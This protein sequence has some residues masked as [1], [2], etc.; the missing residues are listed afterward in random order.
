[1]TNP[2][3]SNNF[4]DDNPLIHSSDS[5]PG[6]IRPLDSSIIHRLSSGQVI[7]DLGQ[8]V[9]ELIENSVDAKSTTIEIIIKNHGIESLT[10]IDNGSGITSENYSKIG[11]KH[12]TSKLNSFQDLSKIK[13]FGFRGEALSSLCALAHVT[14]STRSE[15]DSIGCELTFDNSGH[16]IKQKSQVRNIGTTL[17]LKELFYSLPVRRKTF[18]KNAK[19]DYQKMIDLISGYA[20]IL[21]GIKIHVVHSL[22]GQRNTVLRTQ[23]SLSQLD[24]IDNIYGNKQAENLQ[25]IK[26]ELNEFFNEINNNNNNNYYNNENNPNNETIDLLNK[27]GIYTITG[28]ISKLLGGAG[29]NLNDRHHLAINGRPV[30]LPVIDRA[31]IDAYRECNGAANFPCYIINI[32]IPLNSYDVNV[33]P[34]K[35]VVLIH[36]E[37]ILAA[38]VRAALIQSWPKQHFFKVQNIQSFYLT[39]DNKKNSEEFA[40]NEEEEVELLHETNNNSDREPIPPLASQANLQLV[41]KSIWDDPMLSQ[42]QKSSNENKEVNEEEMSGDENFDKD[43]NIEQSH[44]STSDTNT[45]PRIKTEPNL[46]IIEDYSLTERRHPFFDS[47]DE[48]VSQHQQQAAPKRQKIPLV[49]NVVPTY[50]PRIDNVTTRTGAAFTIELHDQIDQSASSIQTA[51]SDDAPSYKI[52]TTASR[53]SSSSPS[54]LSQPFSSLTTRSIQV[55]FQQIENYW[56]KQ[57]QKQT[58]KENLSNSPAINNIDE[59]LIL[60]STSS[61]SS[62]AISPPPMIVSSNDLIDDTRHRS[63]SKSDFSLM[64]DSIIGQFNLGFIICK[65]N[66]DLWIIDQHAADEKYKYEFYKKTLKSSIHSQQCLSLLPLHLTPIQNSIMIQNKHVFDDLGFGLVVENKNNGNDEKVLGISRIPHYYSHTFGIEDIYEVIAMLNQD[67]THDDNDRHNQ[68]AHTNSNI[69]NHHQHHSHQDNSDPNNNNN[70]IEFPRLRS[71]LASRACRR[72]IMIGESLPLTTM[73]T[74]ISHMSELEQPWS[75]PHGRPTMRHLIDINSFCEQKLNKENSIIKA[76]STETEFTGSSSD[77]ENENEN[78]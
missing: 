29:R 21:M 26:T 36:G 5:S 76:K 6:V 59:S 61:S 72:A 55:N 14:I 30:D 44:F 58:N 28:Y 15:N 4:I 46:V 39:K 52:S 25:L 65:L 20:M 35:R 7:Y 40:A 54:S 48:R 13:T 74:I 45:S 27:Y 38:A 16:C 51:Q 57:K 50:K 75:C 47:F 33:T 53:P 19:R 17:T 11:L 49:N 42:Y 63:I 23:G 24:C 69:N 60:S 68:I 3:H 73:K 43:E 71:I 64:S 32:D 31:I 2:N 34:N 18:T 67:L 78:V 77:D 22:N 66:S 37:N 10:I 8:T 70:V 56:K 12:F 41:N 62:L 1:M 9:K